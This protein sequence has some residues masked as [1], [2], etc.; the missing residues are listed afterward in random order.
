MNIDKIY[1]NHK[2]YDSNIDILNNIIK[3]QRKPIY[4][5]DIEQE[6]S[7]NVLINIYESVYYLTMLWRDMEKLSKYLIPI[8][9]IKNTNNEL[10]KLEKMFNSVLIKPKSIKLRYIHDKNIYVVEDGSIILSLMAIHNLFTIDKNV[11]KLDLKFVHL[12]FDETIVYDNLSIYLSQLD[13][14][15]MYPLEIDK[16]EIKSISQQKT[17]KYNTYTKILLK[18]IKL[19]STVVDIGCNIGSLLF[20]LQDRKNIRRLY[21]IDIN[22]NNINLMNYLITC[23]GLD[24]KT[25]TITSYKSMIDVKYFDGMI[26]TIFDIDLPDIDY[27]LLFDFDNKLANATQQDIELFCLNL[28]QYAKHI[29]IETHNKEIIKFFIRFNMEVI[30]IDNIY[31]LMRC[32]AIKPNKNLL[33]VDLNKENISTLVEYKQNQN[34][35]LNMINTITIKTTD[36]S[37]AFLRLFNMVLLNNEDTVNINTN[38][39]EKCCIC[40][41]PVST[42]HLYSNTPTSFNLVLNEQKPNNNGKKKKKRILFVSPYINNGYLI[43]LMKKM[44]DLHLTNT[45]YDFIC[46]ND[47]PDVVGGESNELEFE[48]AYFNQDEDIN[49]EAYDEIENE[50]K[51]NGFHHIKL[52]QNIHIINRPN[53]P[54]QRHSE[55]CNYFIH[56]IYS[57]YPD[58]WKYDYLCLIDSDVFLVD[59]LD[60]SKEIDDYDII[61]PFIYKSETEYY[62]HTGLYFINM[63]TVTNFREMDW[64]IVWKDTGSGL[65]KFISKNNFKLKVVGKFMGYQNDAYESEGE[66]IKMINGRAL[67][68]WFDKHFVHLRES[69]SGE[70]E[71]MIAHMR[72][73]FAS[74]N[75]D[76]EIIE[77]YFVNY[78]KYYQEKLC[79]NIKLIAV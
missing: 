58:Y 48:S 13:M 14:N 2:F 34:S 62:P 29:I 53:H 66:Y 70:K 33:L 52:P 3:Y 68:V 28:L 74:F 49:I 55:I 35:F 11:K 71:V 5:C 65:Q 56:N 17:N 16:I 75:M 27:I 9:G 10:Q 42:M 21:G 25:R 19:N 79:G 22:Q 7:S 24:I 26:K 40:N 8:H 30:M 36:I 12:I 60:L 63:K 23:F 41:I 4:N 6:E 43:G 15:A 61:A 39:I 59:D 47:A 46:L 64:S 32:C 20:K 38:F 76:P 37:R 67:D 44:L 45:E 54:S 31:I 69:C 77:N 1:I 78:N 18:Y 72:N 50:T 57:L 51:R 73:S